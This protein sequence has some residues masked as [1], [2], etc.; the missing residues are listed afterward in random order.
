[1]VDARSSRGKG[2]SF[3]AAAAAFDD[4]SCPGK[5]EFMLA[6]NVLASG[7]LLGYG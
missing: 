7:N 2:E 1:V 4:V 3:D 5:L 6:G